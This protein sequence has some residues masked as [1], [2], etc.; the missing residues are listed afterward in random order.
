MQEAA[1]SLATQL[2][3]INYL[4]DLC[5][6]LRCSLPQ[7]LAVYRQDSVIPTQLPIFG[8]QTSLQQIQN[9]NPCLI[10]LPDQFDSQGLGSVSLYQGD[11]D[12]FLICSRSGVLLCNL[13]GK[14]FLL[15]NHEVENRT[16][17]AQEGHSLAVSHTADVDTIHLEKQTR[18]PNQNLS[19]F[20][21][22]LQCRTSQ[23]WR[24]DAQS[25]FNAMIEADVPHAH[26]G[27]E[28]SKKAMQN[29]AD[30]LTPSVMASS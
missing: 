21:Y 8:C 28:F 24:Q 10:C 18:V 9:K 3:I 26:Q 17:V 16:W 7:I 5:S 1:A 25:L 6:G 15:Q 23:S 14:A 4:D 19:K 11:M 22:C 13:I 20:R 30:K 29:K 12:H 27:A 2:R